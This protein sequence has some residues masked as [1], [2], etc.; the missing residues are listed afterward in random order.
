MK[1]ARAARGRRVVSPSASSRSRDAGFAML[2]A[3]LIVVIAALFA[4]VAVAA[5]LGTLDVAASDGGQARARTAADAAVAFG[6][7]RAC[8]V[9]ARPECTLHCEVEP[10]STTEV[11]LEAV[12]AV[13]LGLPLSE[14]LLRVTAEV[15][16]GRGSARAVSLVLLRP[17]ALPRGLSVAEDADVQAAVS[18]SGCGMYAGGVV[19]G[20]EHVTL[21]AAAGSD[22]PDDPATPPAAARDFAWGGRWPA[23]G[24]HAGGGIWAAGIDTGELDPLPEAYAADTVGADVPALVELPDAV[25]LASGRVHA[26]DPADAFADG[27]LHLDRLPPT[28]PAGEP[29]A[30]EVAGCADPSA[31]YVVWVSSRGVDGGVEVSG[32]RDAAWAPVTVVIEGDAVLGARDAAAGLPPGPYADGVSAAF[33]GALVVTGR[34]EVAAPSGVDGHVACRRLVVGAPLTLRLAEGW[35]EAPPVGSLEPF[36]VA[37]E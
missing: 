32:V 24:V 31:G 34:L 37:R 33:R 2:G 22:P 30:G 1:R 19:R 6:L 27:V 16:V 29:G 3:L 28:I 25:W 12:E 21:V 14:R 17:T 13:G 11:E 4:G 8:W 15:S 23:A 10:A 18:L 5:A 36:V 7:Q 26:L 9:L 20:R 35:R